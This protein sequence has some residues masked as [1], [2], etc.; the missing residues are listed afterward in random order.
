M[1][2]GQ[3]PGKLFKHLIT[4]AFEVIMKYVYDQDKSFKL[5]TFIAMLNRIEIYIPTVPL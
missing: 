4:K 3:F 1:Q 2:Y 5:T